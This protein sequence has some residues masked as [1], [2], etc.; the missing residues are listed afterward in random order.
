M[1]PHRIPCSTDNFGAKSD[2]YP[3]TDRVDDWFWSFITISGNLPFGKWIYIYIIMYIYIHSY[4]KLMNITIYR[5]LTYIYTWKTV[6]FHQKLWNFTKAHHNIAQATCVLPR[7]SSGEEQ[8]FQAWSCARISM[9]A[10]DVVDLSILTL[11][12]SCTWSRSSC[13]HGCLVSCET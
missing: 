3:L 11:R 4:G 1:N 6:M 13:C 5:S 2:P 7:P 10:E 12:I 8:I 9:L